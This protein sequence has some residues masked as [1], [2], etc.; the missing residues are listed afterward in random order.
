MS[1]N[2]VLM[3][4]PGDVKTQCKQWHTAVRRETQTMHEN[5]LHEQFNLHSLV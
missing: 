2:I 5:K 4:A 3:L 1:Y